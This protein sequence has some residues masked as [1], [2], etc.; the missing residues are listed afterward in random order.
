M[1]SITPPRSLL[2]QVYEDACAQE[3]GLWEQVGHRGPGQAG[4]QPGLWQ[5]WLDAVQASSDAA[6]VLAATI[7][8]ET[9]RGR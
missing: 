6:E 7:P 9:H 4:H 8:I 5:A 2:V 3:S 1:G